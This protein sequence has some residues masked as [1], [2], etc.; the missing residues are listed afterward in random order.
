VGVNLVTRVRNFSIQNQTF[1]ASDHDVQDGCVTPGSHKL[2]RFDFLSYN[3]GN[4]DLVIGSP[5]ARP[6]LFVWSAAHGHYHLKDFNQFLLFNAAGNLATVGY[7]QAFCAI[8][9]ERISPTASPSGQFHDCNTNQGISAG[10]A[11]VYSSYLACQF[12]VIDGVPNGDYTLQS[13]TNTQHKVGEDCYGDNTIWT[14]LRIAANTVQEIDPP[15]IPEDRIPFNRA[16]VAPVQAGGR[17]KVAEG[18]H[19]M[20]DTGTSQWEAQRAVEII[21][22]Y[23]L[24]SLCFVG[25]PRCGDVSPMMYWLT[26]AGRA[27]SGQ[28]PGED[29]IG[30]DRSALAIVQIGDRWKVVEGAHWLL[31]FGPGQGNAVAA[32]HFIRKY[33]F[34]EICF[35]GRPDPSMTYFKTHGRRRI[36]IELIDPRRIEAAIDAPVWWREQDQLSAAKSPWLDLGAECIGTGPKLREEGGFAIEARAA[37]SEIVERYGIKGLALGRQ[38]EI[39]LTESADVVDLGIAHFGEPPSVTAYAGKKEIAQLATDEVPRQIENVRMIGTSIDRVVIT[40]PDGE[41]LLNYVRSHPKEQRARGRQ[42]KRRR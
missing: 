14:G 31:D 8:D 42:K 7:K 32:L 11:D 27:P 18:N 22:H 25:R 40:S 6:D 10:W 36:P 19:W 29:A 35:V 37:R 1:S 26:D 15:F 3:A 34:D 33:R 5:A 39:R 28:L 17:W 23:G 41:S 13:T 4:A 20:L 16:N 12:I 24:G 21:N 9:Y 30:F 38:T 2:L